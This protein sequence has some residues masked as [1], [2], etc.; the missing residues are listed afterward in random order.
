MRP[1][2]T[3]SF[4]SFLLCLTAAELQKYN[5]I[6]SD[7]VLN[8]HVVPHS[9]D[10]V[11][12]LKTVEQYYY[13]DQNCSI[14]PNSVQ[15]ILSTTIDALQQNEAR[16]FVV[17][18]TKFFAMW[19]KEQNDAVKDTV[20]FLVA[21]QQLSFVNGGWCMHDEA[22][23]HFV[24]MI[25]QMTTGHTFLER[26]LGYIPKVGWQ[27]DPFGHSVTQASLM[28]SKMGFDAVYFGRI[29][30]QDLAFRH[31][32]QQCE[33]LWNASTSLEDTTVFWG[34]TGSYSGNYGPPKGFCFDAYCDPE[35]RLL[36][37]TEDTLLERLKDFV[38]QLRAQ[39]DRTSDNHIMLTMGEDFNYMDAA[40]N[41]ANLDLLIAKLMIYQHSG[42]LD[43][44]QFLGPRH[45]RLNIFY[46]SPEYYTQQ[47]H[48]VWKRRQD[49]LSNE[50][51]WKTKTD[52]FFPYSSCENCFWT[53]YFTSR[54]S[55]KRLERVASSLLLASRQIDVLISNE[56]LL[57]EYNCDCCHPFYE[58]EDALGVAQHHDGVSGTAKQH[59]ADDYA[60]RLSSGMHR[61]SAH[62][63]NLLSERMY[64]V[65]STVIHL[66]YCP[67]LNETICPVA[68]EATKSNGTALHVVVYNPLGQNQSTVLRIP[69]ASLACYEITDL[70]NNIS[71]CDHSIRAAM[72]PA[73][74]STYVV[75]YDTGSLPPLGYK[76][77]QI[78]KQC[79]CPTTDIF[80]NPSLVIV[81]KERRRLRK[82]TSTTIAVTNDFMTVEFDT[83]TGQMKRAV[84][85]GTG[86]DLVQ[87][88]G[89]YT[90]FDHQWDHSEVPAVDPTQ[91][92]G[93]YIF[94]P[95]T[96]TQDIHH[97]LPRKATVVDTPQGA[98]V[99]I[100]FHQNWI[101]QTTRIFQSQPFIEVE[102]EIGPI[103]IDDLRGKEIVTRY[104]AS[105]ASKSAFYTDSN[106]RE[107][108]RRQR[109]YRPSWDLDVF[110]PVAGNFYPVNT[111]IFLQD[112][113]ASLSVVVDRSQGGS[114]LQDGT[115]EL[116]VQRR[117][118]AD[119]A[120]GVGEP[121]N[122]T[123]GG[124]T[125]YPPYGNAE[126][127]G[128][129]VIIRGTHRIMIGKGLTGAKL[130]RSLM[131]SAFAEPL[132]FFGKCTIPCPAIF[133]SASFSSGL[134]I[135]L[136]KNVM[137]IT[138]ARLNTAKYLLRLGHQ[139]G[140]D[141]DDELAEPVSVDI[142]LLFLGIGE[143][144]TIDEMTL[145]GNQKWESLQKTKLPWSGETGSTSD[146]DTSNK[147]N[148]VV[149]R[150][151]EIRTFHVTVKAQ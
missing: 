16:T 67:L 26:E 37:L 127:V 107:F 135:G 99:R 133:Q 111:A 122:E 125:P 84:S 9:H 88:W 126:R 20:R 40:T 59:V 83:I 48:K 75:Y 141:D 65:N 28:T 104:R 82:A 64:A 81:E 45:N 139:Y 66:Q 143:V 44:P 102:Y 138:F 100:E 14:S 118:L 27:L 131:D 55:F 142:G 77:F 87:D 121:L 98:E 69:V 136:P 49:L 113:N 123:S 8:V 42:R 85:D 108:L 68:E 86:I 101:R 140:V 56:E 3:F 95:S 5:A 10:D 58:L 22:A 63:A 21:N 147:G 124:M 30:Y 89:Y 24:G 76:T 132:I 72:Q 109:N 96:P 144:D 43:V 74:T 70:S 19:W 145:S 120:K 50:T 11:G 46:S 119:D 110:E 62:V 78:S 39:S 35:Q 15:K 91:N 79:D 150:P 52:D 73:D 60:K 105:I 33:G 149:L 103:P 17:V 71:I 2:F 25:D 51:E 4:A 90:S 7:H 115:L 106:G 92:S 97:L 6:D 53:G 18:E 13:P 129:G 117:N 47:K 151:M 112:K 61:A 94:R 41:F 146:K 148:M 80:R 31:S 116:M 134:S 34:L 93:A 38:Q 114:S 128:D 54:T 137:L 12:W 130:A 32:T 29:D 1:S 23:T 57:D 36:G